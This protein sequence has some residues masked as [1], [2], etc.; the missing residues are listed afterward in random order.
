M[1][2]RWSG[3]QSHVAGPG[4]VR[5]RRAPEG[6][7]LAVSWAKQELK[8]VRGPPVRVDELRIG[9]VERKLR[10]DANPKRQGHIGRRFSELI[11]IRI[12]AE[13]RCIH[14]REKALGGLWEVVVQA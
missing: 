11:R 10:V 5:R 6:S 3:P 2:C 12:L 4:A 9:D 8:V 7:E 1:R 13:R 14:N